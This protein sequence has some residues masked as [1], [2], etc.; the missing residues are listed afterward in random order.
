MALIGK[1]RQRTGLLLGV[2]AVVL[3]LTILMF[4][5]ESQGFMGGSST[6]A[7]GAVNGVAIDNNNFQ[8]KYQSLYGN[9]QDAY[10]SRQA[11]W[12]YLVEEVIIRDETESAGLGISK[13]EMDEMLYGARLSPIIQ[14]I[15]QVMDPS[16]GAPNRQVLDQIKQMDQTGQWPEQTLD[17]KNYWTEIKNQ[18]EKDRL[19]SKLSTLVAKSVYIPNWMVEQLHSFNNLQADFEYVR[20]PFDA[21]E[22]SKVKV[23]DS[24]LQAYIEENKARYTQT[25]EMRKLDYVVFDVIPTYADTNTARQFLADLIPEWSAVTGPAD[26][27]SFILSNSGVYSNGYQKRDA[28]ATSPIQ[29]D[30]FA[31]STGSIIGPYTDGNSFA[32]TKI[33]DRRSMPD[34]CQVRHIL[35]SNQQG[36]RT[37]AAA[38]SL[39]D[40]LL[41]IVNPSNFAEL[42]AKFSDDGGSKNNGGIYTWS[43]D[44]GLYPEYY[45]Y[46]FKTGVPG[47]IKIVKT[48]QGGYHIMNIMSYKGGNSPVVR[49]VTFRERIA[50]GEET[51]RKVANEAND[52]LNKCTNLDAMKKEASAKGLTL[53]T[54]NGLRKNDYAVGSLGGGED[55]RRLVRWA[56]E[57]K[58][59]SGEVSREVYEF[60]EQGELFVNKYVVAAL[61]SIQPSGTPSVAS[62][63]EEIEPRV[64]A[65]KKGELL[66]KQITG[67]DLNAIAA[68]YSAK[69]DTARTIPFSTAGLPGGGF[70]P[71]VI[72]AAFKLEPNSV[73]KPVIGENGVYVVRLVSKNANAD[74]PAPDMAMMRRQYSSQYAGQLRYGLVQE[75]KK[76]AKIKDNRSNFF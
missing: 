62:L 6:T 66:Q 51:Q 64:K 11:L 29:N 23:T 60:Q 55:S 4:A 10:G 20:V 28:F 69:V 46:C 22:D 12:D 7:M 49:T 30:L 38:K 45:D 56:Y 1:I 37:D 68:Q 31:L 42:A 34:S 44:A 5:S 63:R 15:P 54:S 76:G 35:I 13:Q 52:F 24:D 72:G 40:S 36:V 27:S 19:Q 17:F 75:L 70:E 65:L 47:A 43:S 50:P 21:V 33:V 59:K 2:M 25:D 8:R 57:D 32:L 71:K 61:K 26:D 9:S 39:A 14:Q 74:A 67:T 73:S 18:V 16:T 3:V 48:A 53:Q 58:R 41:N